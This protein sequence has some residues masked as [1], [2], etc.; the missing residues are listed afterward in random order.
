MLEARRASGVSAY[1]FW[2]KLYH[3]SARGNSYHK[4]RNT[5]V[6][7]NIVTI[8]NRLFRYTQH[9]RSIFITSQ[10]SIQRCMLATWAKARYRC[11]N[12][13]VSKMWLQLLRTLL[14][15]MCTVKWSLLR[16]V[17]FGDLY[18]LQTYCPWS[19]F[20]WI[21]EGYATERCMQRTVYI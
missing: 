20:V 16:A 4:T 17:R 15:Q 9:Q 13:F 7:F 11:D 10:I 18:V 14:D 1:R 8:K 21:L 19:A 12:Y 2:L 3:V 5:L 6:S